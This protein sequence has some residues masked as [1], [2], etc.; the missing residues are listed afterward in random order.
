MPHVLYS[1]GL[2]P[3]L[4]GTSALREVP[5]V[6]S[7]V[8]MIYAFSSQGRT[9]GAAQLI[10]LPLPSGAL[11]PPPPTPATNSRYMDSR[12][13]FPEEHFVGRRIIEVGAGCGLTSIY[14][15]LRGADVT[16]TDMDVGELVS[17]VWRRCCATRY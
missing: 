13:V 17:R 4:S 7:T 14:A 10:P 6:R 16:I 12:Q 11:L 1:K 9:K 2:C 5:S 15:A 8:A 3:S